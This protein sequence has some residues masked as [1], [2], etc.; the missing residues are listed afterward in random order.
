MHDSSP[1]STLMTVTFAVALMIMLGWLLRV[2]Q[3]VLLPVLVGVIAVYVLVT[4]AD[5]LGHVPVIRRLGRSWR[6]VLVL[7]LFLAAFLSLGAIVAY[8]AA[9]IR[10]ALPGYIA[11]LDA[12]QAR[13]VDT[14]GLDDVPSLADYGERVMDAVDL[15]ALLPPV[16]TTLSS[17]GSVLLAATL[18]AVFILA[19]LD[20]LPDR[21]RLALGRRDQA[22]ATLDVVRRINQ[23]IG[24]YLAAKTLINAL[25]GAVSWVILV[26]LGIE[27]A[28][29]WALLI[30]LLNY[31]PYVGSIMA[32][33]FPVTMSL[34]QFGSVPHTLLTLLA[35]VIPQSLVG[36]YL[37][38]KF[39]GKSVNLSPFTVLLALSVWSALWG[40]MGAVLAIP[41][42]SMITIVLA[43]FDGT[44]FI[45]VLLSGDG[46]V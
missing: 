6:R 36:Y 38:P 24:D 32:V 2:G 12:F 33:A 5:A 25:L 40:L 27:H 19:D 31:I 46:E 13:V 26:L 4:A 45:A 44:R 14:L 8:S 28:V 10:A 20:R 23:R 37:E 35:L 3:S 30:A 21:T 22:E 17:S 34:I 11:N 9:A 42:T 29:F 18:Y 1:N 16:L 41:L 15:V 39:L 7:T 43:A